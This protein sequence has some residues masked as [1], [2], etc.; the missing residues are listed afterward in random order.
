MGLGIDRLGRQ[1]DQLV[2]V[3]VRPLE[4]LAGLVA[5]ARRDGEAGRRA[6]HLAG[7]SG[8]APQPLAKEGVQLADGDPGL[9]KLHLDVVAPVV[10][11]G[12]GGPGRHGPGLHLEQLVEQ[13]AGEHPA[14]KSALSQIGRDREGFDDHPMVLKGLPGHGADGARCG[15]AD[16]SRDQLQHRFHPVAEAAP[17]QPGGLQLLLFV[18]MLLLQSDQFGLL[19]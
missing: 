11:I 15:Q 10:G 8:L 2:E 19:A 3:G 6:H 18:Q 4:G 9:G 13:L 7:D 5:R 16:G 1:L 14:G 17:A 12:G